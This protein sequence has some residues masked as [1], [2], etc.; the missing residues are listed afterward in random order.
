M[1]T[2]ATDYDC[3]PLRSGWKAG[4]CKNERKRRIPIEASGAPWHAE[5]MPGG[6]VVQDANGQ[7]LAYIYSRHNEAGAR[8]AKMLTKSEARP[9]AV[10][11]ARLPELPGKA[12]HD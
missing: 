10:N 7:A 2:S 12:D 6:Y 9:I 4:G 3:Q 11:V 8:Q 1:R 5:P